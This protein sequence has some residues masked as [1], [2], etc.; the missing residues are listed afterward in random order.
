MVFKSQNPK[1]SIQKSHK[2][3][4][5]NIRYKILRNSTFHGKTLQCFLVNYLLKRITTVNKHIQIKV[6]GIF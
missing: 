1:A 4:L 6:T 5:T 2:Q 3:V